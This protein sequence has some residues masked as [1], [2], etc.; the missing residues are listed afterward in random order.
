MSQIKDFTFLL[1]GADLEMS[2][3]RKMLDAYKSSPVPEFQI[4]YVDHHLEWGARLSNYKDLISSI[5]ANKIIGIELIEDIP[6]PLNYVSFDHHNEN[7][8]R[9]SS[10]EQIAEL[11][12]VRLNRYQI[13]V[14]INDRSYIPGM[15]AFGAT[16]KEI[17]EIRRNDRKAQGV[18]EEDE[19]LA[20][21]SI[22]NHRT[23]LNNITVI[24]SL[25]SKFSTIT[26]RLFPFKHLLIY[27]IDSLTY[28]GQYSGRLANY[29]HQMIVMKEA[30]TGGGEFGY[31]GIA[32]NVI[33]TGDLFQIKD[34]IL[35]II[36]KEIK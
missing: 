28:Y 35:S 31:F 3:I 22:Q 7:V 16:E 26:D 27:N 8:E 11:L 32:K 23:L 13:L 12:K 25:T 29:F 6:I 14:A 1:G 4:D 10:L 30:Y 36:S 24:E 18:T 15:I 34:Q 17:E 33:S 9:L 5:N 19:K 21:Q 2:E 20:E